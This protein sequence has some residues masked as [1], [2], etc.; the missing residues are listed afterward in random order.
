MKIQAFIQ[1]LSSP[2]AFKYALQERF[3][4]DPLESSGFFEDFLKGFI[5]LISQQAEFIPDRLEWETFIKKVQK[6]ALKHVENESLYLDQNE[7]SQIKFLNSWIDLVAVLYDLK[8]FS[9]GNLQALES[10]I[11]EKDFK[12]QVLLSLIKNLS[13]VE[14]QK[15]LFENFWSKLVLPSQNPGEREQPSLLMQKFYENCNGLSSEIIQHMSETCESI[16]EYKN[17]PFYVGDS[18]EKS[19]FSHLALQALKKYSFTELALRATTFK[20][21][22]ECFKEFSAQNLLT[23]TDLETLFNHAGSLGEKGQLL[24]L[25]GPLCDHIF[26]VLFNTETTVADKDVLYQR[27]LKINFSFPKRKWIYASLFIFNNIAFA[28]ALTSI[29]DAD[30][31]RASALVNDVKTWSWYTWQDQLK[32]VHDLASLNAKHEEKTYFKELLQAQFAQLLALIAYNGSTPL[33]RS[34]CSQQEFVDR[35]QQL[36]PIVQLVS[37]DNVRNLLDLYWDCESNEQSTAQYLSCFKIFQETLNHNLELQLLMLA[38]IFRVA[39][40]QTILA[41]KEIAWFCAHVARR[42]AAT[43]S[44]SKEIIKWLS[45]LR[46]ESKKKL[47]CLFAPIFAYVEMFYSKIDDSVLHAVNFQPTNGWNRVSQTGRD[48]D[49]YSA[50]K[51]AQLVSAEDASASLFELSETEEAKIIEFWNELKPAVRGVSRSGPQFHQ[52]ASGNTK[53]N[54]QVVELQPL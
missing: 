42:L 3:L 11:K 33:S 41:I 30:E 1:C 53:N 2:G 54:Y 49:S 12:P 51:R 5:L 20:E 31:R 39:P 47:G 29:G 10:S 36:Q 7:E 22:A 14:E 45:D 6:K 34:R 28:E 18:G 15:K 9:Y 48:L 37:E 21:F 38:Y 13:S 23:P 52:P 50:K 43:E 17:R 27:L 4:N 19:N 46:S 24:T 35:V 40:N 8:K 25:A 16:A 26:P 44:S 32:A